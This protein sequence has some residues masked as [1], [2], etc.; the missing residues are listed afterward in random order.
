MTGNVDHALRLSGMRNHFF[1]PN[2][3]ADHLGRPL[4]AEAESFQLDFA[5]FPILFWF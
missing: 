2:P 5:F 1:E 4:R 3:A